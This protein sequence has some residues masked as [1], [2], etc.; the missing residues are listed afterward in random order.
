MND[1]K[2]QEESI[3]IG[4]A[5]ELANKQREAILLENPSDDWRAILSDREFN[6]LGSKFLFL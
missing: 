6:Y 2:L 5:R 1:E 4:S 3:K